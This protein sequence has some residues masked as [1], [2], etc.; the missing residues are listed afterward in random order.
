[1]TVGHADCLMTSDIRHQ[2]HQADLLCEGSLHCCDQYKK[3]FGVPVCL[4]LA[5]S[6]EHFLIVTCVHVR[7]ASSCQLIDVAEHL[8]L[9]AA[10]QGGDICKN[11]T[12]LN[13]KIE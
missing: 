3:G 5:C 4:S 1:M 9:Q 6:C 13:C 2:F 10:S 11:R 7:L 12:L 8:F